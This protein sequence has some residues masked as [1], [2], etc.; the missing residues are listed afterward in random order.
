MTPDTGHA[1]DAVVAAGAALSADRRQVSII[2]TNYNY[3]RYVGA[4]IES[5]LAQTHPHCEV[6]IVDDGSKDDSRSILRAY[7]DR[8]GVR[9]IFQDNGGQAAAFNTGFAAAAGEFILFLDADDL[10]RPDAVATVLDQWRDGMSRCQFPLQMIDSDGRHMGLH[11]FS[12][13]M[14]D[15]DLHW[16]AVVSGYIRFIPTSGNVFARAAL[17]PLFPIAAA[18]WRLCADAHVVYQ[19]VAAGSVQNLAM[20]LGSY[21][22][23]DSNAWY[24]EGLD[25]DQLRQIWRQMFQQWESLIGSVQ[26][27]VVAEEPDSRRRAYADHAALYLYR[28]LIGGHFSQPDLVPR[29]KLRRLIRAARRRAISASLPWR[30]KLLYVGC[31][32]LATARGWRFAAAGR[33]NAHASQR[34]SWLHRLV[35]R[36]KGDDFYEWQRAVAPPSPVEEFPLDQ[37]IQ[38]GRGRE[39]NRYL[40]YGWERSDP[41]QAATGG[42]VAALI[43]QVP[44][45]GG[46][47]AVELDL[48]P[49]VRPGIE[50]QR[51]TID[52]NGTRVYEGRMFDRTLVRFSVPRAVA[53]KSDTLELRL[54]VP[55]AFVP[56]FIGGGAG[57]YR[58][59]AFT[60][61]TMKMTTSVSTAGETA[62]MFLLAGNRAN[63]S[64][65]HE[66]GAMLRGWHAPDADGVARIRR[67]EAQLSLTILDGQALD[68]ILEL[69]F[70]VE[71]N[72]TV[73]GTT[74][75]V[76]ASGE[77]LGIVDVKR[78]AKLRVLIPPGVIGEAGAL[79]LSLVPSGLWQDGEDWPAGW[80]RA[81][82]P[83]LRS[84]QLERAPKLAQHPVMRTGLVLNFDSGGTGLPFK[85]SGWHKPDGQG[86]V[87][88]DT[89]AELR[90][91]WLDRE[92]DIFLTGVV[93]PAIPVQNAP[94]QQLTIVC[95]G[96]TVAVYSIAEAAEI[97]AIIPPGIVGEDGAL[98]M[99]FRVT[100]LLRPADFGSDG[101]TRLVGVG[102]R[103]LS[104]E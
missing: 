69:E 90:G 21:R 76:S 40:W 95:N 60:L 97:T 68:H 98:T 25:R 74:V 82:G 14:D 13:K 18:N 43:G 96:C 26:P 61:S 44:Q 5:A 87:M 85:F 8:P 3:A 66:A 52:A 29:K 2:I 51:L 91:L 101:D 53:R 42:R 93:Y 19:S 16:K 20:P 73:P 9:L 75:E 11:P 27:H 77:L 62:G 47:L 37:T 12:H 57:D 46:D 80:P 36:C 100:R 58:P 38:F 10:L 55:D 56:R 48:M 102:L 24:R 84:L 71:D 32:L 86:S 70:A 15:G 30:Q 41:M 63:A 1:S 72:E 65:L 22:V 6:I 103:L 104:L 99:E 31:F 88:A 78:Q 23:H 79:A 34:P 7:R 64:E 67:A 35:E 4:A 50:W 39:G 83:G 17:A 59:Q 28:R 54:T 89:V 94:P 92:N 81:I 33:W 49:M 45:G